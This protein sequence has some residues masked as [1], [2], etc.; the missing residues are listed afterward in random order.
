MKTKK[1]FLIIPLLFLIIGMGGC[2]DKNGIYPEAMVVKELPK[3]SI[4]GNHTKSVIIQSQKELKAVFSEDELKRIDDLQ[5]IDFSKHT[6]LLGYGSYANEV[7]NME[8]SFSKTTETSYTYLLKIDGA[9]TRPD[10]F[11]YGILVGKLPKPVEVIFKI[12][13]LHLEN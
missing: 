10:S 2:E 5:Q 1:V 3:I 13:K 8:H 6:L 9:A 11:R 12:E 4:L 7:A